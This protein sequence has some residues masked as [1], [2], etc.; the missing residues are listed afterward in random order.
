[1]TDSDSDDPE[2]QERINSIVLNCGATPKLSD[3]ELN[4]ISDDIN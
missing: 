4:V 2:K 1:M 3:L